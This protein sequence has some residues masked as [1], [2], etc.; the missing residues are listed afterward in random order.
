MTN[1][2]KYRHT[3]VEALQISEDE[4]HEELVYQGIDAWDSVGHMELVSEIEDVFDIS[5]ETEDVID[6]ASYQ[7]GIKILE[8][9]GVTVGDGSC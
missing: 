4:V 1:L 8:K 2:E 7:Q 3:F 5:M 9:Y 6:F